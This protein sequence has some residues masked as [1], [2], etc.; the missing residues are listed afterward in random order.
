M[1]GKVERQSRVWVTNWPSP[2][3]A[4]QVIERDI[5]DGFAWTPDGRIVYDTNDDG[6]SHLWLADAMGSQRQQLSPDNAEERQPEVSPDGKLFAFVSKRSGIAAL[7]VMDAEGRNARRL[8]PDGVRAWRPRFAPDGQSIFFMMERSD[9]PTLARVAIAGGDPVVIADDVYADTYFDV[10]PD[11]LRLAYSLKDYARHVT[12]VVVRQLTGGSASTYF[13]IEPGY[14][15]RWT[16]DGQ[17]LAYAQYPRDK[18]FGEALW[19]QPVNGGPPQQVL[20]VT[21]DLLYWVAWSRDGKQLAISHGRFAR[22]VVLVSRN[23]ELIH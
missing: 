4:R 3:P 16:P 1:A 13:D 10:S 7:W 17:N 2:R 22:D 8:T 21:P 23:N 12:R 14:F 18:R 20:E 5:A 6:R 15:L 11:G 19:L 9:R